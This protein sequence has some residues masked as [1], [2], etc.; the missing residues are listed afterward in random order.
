MNGSVTMI[1]FGESSPKKR[2]LVTNNQVLLRLRRNDVNIKGKT[3]QDTEK[4][5]GIKTRWWSKMTATEQAL[6]AAKSACKNAENNTEG[7][8]R[9]HKLGLIHS[10]GSTPDF[11][12]PACSCQLHGDLGIPT[13][14]CE[15]RDISLA[16]SSA[17]DALLLASTRMRYK[18][19]VYGLVAI[20]ESIGTSLNAPTSLSYCLWGDGGGAIVLEYQ[21]D[22][23][24]EFGFILDKN[25]ADGQFAHWTQSRMLGTHPSH[26]SYEHPDASMEGFGQSIQRYGIDKVSQ[27]AK[28]LLAE[29]GLSAPTYF[30]PHNSNLSM[31]RGIG[32]RIGV[33]PEQVLTRIDER[34]NTSSA[35]I[36]ITLAHYAGLGRFQ[37]GD[38]LLLTAFGGGM[39]IALSL[40]RW[41]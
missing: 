25:I 18:K 6:A 41:P 34:G 13:G 29:G 4:L 31:V 1:G 2:E 8:F 10:G 14:N 7:E 27:A 40:Y 17:I 33:P 5:T 16:C 24:P 9:P 20:G 15:A 38:T 21:S 26:R 36:L 12:F 32:K 28:E 19:I 3:G 22:G 30:L 23:D 11:V 39:S 37:R 35:S